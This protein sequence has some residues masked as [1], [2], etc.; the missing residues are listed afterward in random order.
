MPELIPR[1]VRNNRCFRT[2]IGLILALVL[3]GLGHGVLPAQAVTPAQCLSS[4]SG[5]Y[6]EQVLWS[7]SYFQLKCGR[8]NAHSPVGSS[9]FGFRHI[10][11]DGHPVSATQTAKFYECMRDAI[12]YGKDSTANG[13]N[14]QRVLA[15]TDGSSGRV[16]Y[17]PKSPPQLHS[18]VTAYTSG[19]PSNQWSVGAALY[20][21]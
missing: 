7:Y 21:G 11:Y 13:N 15:E 10:H 6:Q 18:I 17:L 5:L 14:R 8:T 19:S 9:G 12:D 1:R 4:S 20:G 16:V 2:R 3:G